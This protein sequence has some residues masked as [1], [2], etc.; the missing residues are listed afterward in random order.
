[1]ELEVLVPVSPPSVVERPLASRLDG[2]TGRRIGLLANGK[3]NAAELLEFVGAGL[4]ARL[5]GIELVR[6][7]KPQGPTIGAPAE[8]MGR[9]Q[10]CEAVILAIAD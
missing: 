1:M 7:T 3:A 6:E 10:K 9:L 8:V 2:L 4:G 5:A